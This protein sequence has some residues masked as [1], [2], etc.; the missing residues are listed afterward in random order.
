MKNTPVFTLS[1]SE[2]SI[3]ASLELI[4]YDKSP[5]INISFD[6]EKPATTPDTLTRLSE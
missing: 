3:D 5:K 1:D 2:K 6:Q 4:Q